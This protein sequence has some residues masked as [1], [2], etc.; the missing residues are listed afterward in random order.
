MAVVASSALRCQAWWGLLSDCEFSVSESSRAYLTI[1]ENL[2]R[3]YLAPY[4]CNVGGRGT[5]VL[6][7]HQQEGRR[8]ET[9]TMMK[10]CM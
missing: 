5:N 8:I 4:E 7:N 1:L 9:T 2:Y 6:K 3:G 10:K